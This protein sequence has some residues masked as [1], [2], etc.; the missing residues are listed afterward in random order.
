MKREERRNKPE[1]ATVKGME[2]REV[3]QN[4]KNGEVGRGIRQERRQM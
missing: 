4:K 3:G 2:K 1:V